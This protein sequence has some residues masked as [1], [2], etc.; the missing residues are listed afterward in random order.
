MRF[1]RGIDVKEALSVGAK[2]TAITVV[3]VAQLKPY[4]GFVRLTKEACHEFFKSLKN[5]KK[6]GGTFY[7]GD[8]KKKKHISKYFG[9]VIEFYGTYYYIPK[10][11]YL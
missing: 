8:G 11:L 9:R 1:E 10:D 6:L 5:N 7:L 2:Q 4:K 3:G